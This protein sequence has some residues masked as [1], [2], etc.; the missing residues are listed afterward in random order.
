V[1]TKTT[2]SEISPS[3]FFYR[4]RDL[5]GF[6][7]PARALYM[8]VRE[9]VENSLDAAELQGTLP[10]VFVRI[11][12]DDHGDGAEPISY[13]LTV[14]DNGP[15][16]DSHHVPRAFGK[17]FYGSKYVLRQ[18]RG[19]FGMGGTMA[20]LYGQITTN[21]PVRIATSTDGKNRHIFEMLI[22]IS[23]NKPIILKKE[24]ED[25]GGKTGTRVDVR[26]EGDFARAAQKIGDYF[27]QTALVASYANLTLV[28][29]EGRLTTY[30]RATEAMPV[31]PKETLPHP[32]GIDVEAFKRLIK[33]TEEKT[34]ISFMT[35]HFHR[36]GERTA[37]KFLAFAGIDP[38]SKP[39]KLNNEQVVKTVDALQRFP[40]FLPP[41]ASCLSPVGEQ[42]LQTGIVKELQ[43]EFSTF[44]QRPP[45]SY[46]GFPFMIEV[47]LAYGGKV[48]EP[49]LK[50]IRYAN[51]I[52][53][54]Y[55]ESSDVSFKVLNEEIDWR[56]YHVPDDAPLTMITH[57][58]STRV[59]YKTVGKEY[60][61]DRPE[62]EK[63]LRNAIREALRRLSLFLSKKGSM[64]A[65][66]RKMNIYGKYLPLIAKFSMEMA[67][68]KKLP[69]YKKLMGA[70][71]LEEAA[72]A[73]GS[74]EAETGE[75]TKIEQAKIEDYN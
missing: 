28:D 65:V 33:L 3:E 21:R 64:E 57:I 29:P 67:G 20:I 34:M 8:A 30:E 2:F 44:V 26:L 24:T 40:E 12:G 74:E 36:V 63:E 37:A 27:K 14:S 52:P 45:S 48:L 54:L 23:E 69:D 59:P 4:N 47:G 10:D 11:F 70:E 42:I 39:E 16:V 18:S 35:T 53:L 49:G 72:A 46:S 75:A 15:G 66:Q 22:D 55:D 32:H 1:S 6:T 5:A 38:K 7:N 25:A 19:M 41:D 58:C 9:L 31:T 60:I 13:N 68:K 73:E 71:M 17:V 56:R 61:A 43:P 50:L 51:R 62:I